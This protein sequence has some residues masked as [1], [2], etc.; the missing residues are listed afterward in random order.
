MCWPRSCGWTG[1]I[2]GRLPGTPEQAEAI[3]LVARAHQTMIWDRT[4]HVL[5][6]R[7]A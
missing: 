6:L 7:R 3:K 4:C 2:T 5:R 1:P